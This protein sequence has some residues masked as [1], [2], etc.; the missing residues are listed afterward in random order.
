VAPPRAGE[1][2]A[3]ASLYQAYKALEAEV[4]E[5]GGTLVKLVGDGVLAVFDAPSAAVRGAQRFRGAVR[6]V[7]PTATVRAAIHCGP[8]AAVTL[9]E[10]L[11]YFG[12]SVQGTVELAQ[13]A[14]DGEILVSDDVL[15]DPG[16]QDW[17]NRQARAG[18]LPRRRR[19]RVDG[20]ETDP[21]AIA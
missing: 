12:N 21:L 11:D 10:R 3:F 1:A 9:N 18:E 14:S 6:R 5:A 15:A 19:R 2:A 8:A 7:D 20:A 4:V 16:V 13:E 17:L